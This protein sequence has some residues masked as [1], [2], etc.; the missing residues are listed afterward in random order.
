M[1][2]QDF[3]IKELFADAA[4]FDSKFTVSES[5]W[6]KLRRRQVKSVDFDTDVWYRNMADEEPTLF[7]SFPVPAV[8]KSKSKVPELQESVKAVVKALKAWRSSR[9]FRVRTGPK[10]TLKY[11][12][13]QQLMAYWS[14]PKAIVTTTDLHI[15][16]TPMEKVIDVDALSEFNLLP[17]MEEETSSL[18]MMSLIISSRG[19]VTDSHS[20]DLDISNYCFCGKKLWLAWDTH[21]GLQNG[22]DDCD[23]VPID[24]FAKF[25][26]KTWLSLK[27]A[28]WVLVEDGKI[29][30]LPGNMAHRVVTLEPY[31]GVGAFYISFP[32]ALRTVSRWQQHT[33]NWELD[34]E[35]DVENSTRQEVASVVA[36]TLKRGPKKLKKHAG[37]DYRAYALESWNKAYPVSK[38][39]KL[40]SAS[41]IAE[42]ISHSL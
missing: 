27:S 14:N 15:R 17:L 29:L 34:K 21:E 9:R 13:M 16:E 3:D 35:L 28:R 20:D 10:R 39:A 30:Y 12:T 26:L 4:S 38:R 40:S 7:H 11:V 36:R 24:D 22:L 2:K 8:K 23:R 32:N 37:V 6:A 31:I 41:S 25:D 18:E 33:A 42:A 1:A 5:D 19:S